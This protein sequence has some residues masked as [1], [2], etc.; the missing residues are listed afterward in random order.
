MNKNKLT[1]KIDDAPM[2][3]RVI[4]AVKNSYVE[5]ILVI[6]RQRVVR[7][8]AEKNN[9]KAIYNAYASRGQS[10]AIKLGIRAADPQSRGYM[11]F[12]GDQPFLETS[13][14]NQL[15][16]AFEKETQ[17]ITLPLYNGKRGN[18]VIFPIGFRNA[19]L[20][21]AGDQGGREI[22]EQEKKIN[23]IT[24]ED[25]RIG[26]DIDTWQQYEKLYGGDEIDEK[27]YS[28]D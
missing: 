15:I 22:I 4:R 3:E 12:V 25:N 24:I 10:E 16:E 1:L 6:Y 11:F 26:I 17:V 8:I 28:G 21:I 2:I 20:S 23:C 13:T 14:I 19:L 7:K 18:P 27:K 5:D 9:V